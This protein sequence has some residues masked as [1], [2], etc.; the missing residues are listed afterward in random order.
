MSLPSDRIKKINIPVIENGVQT[1]T[2]EYDIIP[3]ML[4]KD[5]YS[6]E[7]PTLTK[8]ST[9]ALTDDIINVA[10][11]PATTSATLTGITIGNTNY[12]V[13]AGGGE[14]DAYLKSAS[15]SGNTLTIVPKTGSNIVFTPTFTEQHIGDVVSVGATVNSGLSI[16][17]TTANP[18]VGVASTHKLP[19][20]T[21]WADKANDAEVV[22]KS[23][24][25]M[26]GQLVAQNN[27]AYTTA[28]VRNI[29]LSTS[30]P[31]STDGGNGDIWIVYKE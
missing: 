5:G 16:G 21:E 24:D 13:S 3:D 29:I 31:T 22:H 12:A 8:D 25:T 6:A 30:E 26:I 9:L 2:K 18:T 17:G 28:Q 19:T 14:P 23:G 11:N 20:T 10:A 4:G 27:I 15:A 1:S 7:L